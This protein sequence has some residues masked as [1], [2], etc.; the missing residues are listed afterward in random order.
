MEDYYLPNCIQFISV[1]S[2]FGPKM[3]TEVIKTEVTEDRRDFGTIVYRTDRQTDRR[4]CYINSV[5][6]G[7][8]MSERR[9]TVKIP[10]SN[11][12]VATY[13]DR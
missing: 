10:S 12:G 6:R 13:V 9:G 7:V 3:R 5:S 1:L 11:K 8:F 2:H 4:N